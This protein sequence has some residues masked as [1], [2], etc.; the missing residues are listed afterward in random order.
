MVSDRA[1]IFHKCIP[2]Q[3]EIFLSIKVNINCQGQGQMPVMMAL[4]FHKHSLL[5]FAEPHSSVKS[6]QE[7]R[8]GDCWFDPGQYCL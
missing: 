3:Q 6:L 2:L 1:S 4:I 8:T 5:I 7:L